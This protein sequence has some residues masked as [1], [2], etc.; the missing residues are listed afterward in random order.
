MSE[1]LLA[2][3]NASKSESVKQIKC[4]GFGK[5][6]ELIAQLDEN[7]AIVLVGAIN[8]ISKESKSNGTKTKVTEFKIS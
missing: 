4:V 3:Q 7:Q 8:I 6:A 1:F 5:L 2:F